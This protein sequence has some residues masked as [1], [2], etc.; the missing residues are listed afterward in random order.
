MITGFEHLH[1][2]LRWV[3]LILL[4]AVI[5]RAFLGMRNHAAFTPGAAKLSMYT[6]ATLHLQLL[7][8]LA[9]YL[10]G[11]NGLNL[12]AEGGEVMANPMHRFFAVEHITGMLIAVALATV[13][14]IGSKKATGDAAKFRRQFVFYGI[15]L[16]LILA[17]IPWPFRTELG[18]HGWI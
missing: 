17:M 3:A 9:L 10:M 14:H 12:F 7:L 5:I 8:G 1:S 6:M 15:A 4:L 18:A 11:D 2:T 13:A 16:V